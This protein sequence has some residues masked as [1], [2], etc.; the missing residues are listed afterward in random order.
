MALLQILANVLSA[1]MCLSSGAENT[2][3]GDGL[4][5]ASMR[6]VANIAAALVLDYFGHYG[7]VEKSTD[8]AMRSNLVLPM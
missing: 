3:L 6:S 4:G 8:R 5:R 1:G 2:A 7:C